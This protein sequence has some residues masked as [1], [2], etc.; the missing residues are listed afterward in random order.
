MLAMVGGFTGL[1]GYILSGDGVVQVG[2]GAV[3]RGLVDPERQVL[4]EGGPG[5]GG[6]NGSREALP[7]KL[8]VGV[9]GIQWNTI[10]VGDGRVEVA[11]H[12]VDGIRH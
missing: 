11:L 1:R 10:P 6:G 8:G 5:I 2:Q 3:G 9:A 4:E 7:V 12:L